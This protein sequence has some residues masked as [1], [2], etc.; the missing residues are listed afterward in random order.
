MNALV[1]VVGLTPE[2]HAERA[3]AVGASEVYD[4]LFNPGPLWLRKTGRDAGRDEDAY[5]RLGNAIEPYILGEYER[6]YGVEVSPKP[7]AFRYG[8]MVAHLDAVAGP[9][10]IR[11]ERAI[12]CKWR[13]SREGWGA[14]G[15]AD[16]P[17]PVLLQVQQ[18]MGV[19]ALDLAHV[20]VLFMRPPIVVYAVEFDPE[21]FDM[22]GAGVDRFWRYVETDTPPP[23]NAEQ[24]EALDVLRKLYPG[25]D[26]TRIQATRDLEHW[27]TVMEDASTLSKSYG[28]TAEGAKAHLLQAM[29]TAAELEFADGKL[30]RRKLVKRKEYLVQS[31][32]YIDARLTNPKE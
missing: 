15:S 18:Q 25:T 24:P 17:M 3:Q 23:I 1:P 16:V 19:A 22:L 27:R 8:R 28:L 5:T 32:E 30:L 26:G 20:A 9:S 21:L 2:Q 31:T 29:K 13:G 12:E 11:P 6:A 7:A 10:R 4:A 14:E